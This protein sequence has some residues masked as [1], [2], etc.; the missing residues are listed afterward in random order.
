MGTCSSSISVASAA[1]YIVDSPFGVLIPEDYLLEFAK[2]FT[3]ERLG[4]YARLSCR[5]GDL[6]IIGEG[7]LD[8]STVMPSKKEKTGN[9]SEFL[10]RKQKG[11][12]MMVS[13]MQRDAM[14]SVSPSNQA[15]SGMSRLKRL[16]TL[17]Q[18]SGRLSKLKEQGAHK[19]LLSMLDTTTITAPEPALVLKMDMPKFRSWEAAVAGVEGLDT[20]RIKKVMT[21]TIR[22]YLS[23]IPLLSSVP[24]SKLNVLA[25]V[26]RYEVKDAG[27]VICSEGERGD[28]VYVVLFGRLGVRLPSASPE[29]ELPPQ[30]PDERAGA[31]MRHQSVSLASLKEGD[32]FGEL[33]VVVNI[34]RQA[35]VTATTPCLLVSIE[36]ASFQN[37]LKVNEALGGHVQRKVKNQLLRKLVSTDAPFVDPVADEALEGLADAC[38]LEEHRDGEA[39]FEEGDA[40]DMFYIVYHGMV[41][42]TRRAGGGETETLDRFTAGSYF[43][44]LSL[45]T[46]APRKATLRCI[47]DAVL[48]AVQK[49]DFLGLFPAGAIAE[50]WMRLLGHA[51]PLEHVMKHATGRA[52]FREHLATE[53]NLEHLDFVDT[54]DAFLDDFDAN[55]MKGGSSGVLAQARRIFEKYLMQGGPREV[56][57]PDV[58]RQAVAASIESGRVSKDLFVV[59]RNEIYKLLERDSYARFKMS[60]QF[61]ELLSTLGV[62]DGR[63]SAAKH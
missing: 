14:A 50:L 7:T 8:V 23:N 57:I 33:A 13:S 10:C 45:L 4:T 60:P 58:Q 27:E 52:M 30:E 11:D 40:G 28:K 12:I 9:I 18:K 15:P 36:R 37:F 19:N 62:Y 41:G 63:K 43:G 38:R 17:L 51:S 26:A 21:T 35:T 59:A 48:V 3:V 5:T 31:A 42:A 6:F 25:E 61:G 1:E 34:P 39:I 46:G 54:V 49:D 16:S 2:C 29:D 24:P 22:D 53:L 47:G 32:Y 44:E 55:C 20:T 56:N